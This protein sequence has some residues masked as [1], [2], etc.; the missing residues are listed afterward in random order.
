MKLIKI[1]FSLLSLLIGVVLC[2]PDVAARKLTVEQRLELLESELNANKSELQKTK[3]ELGRYKSKLANLQQTLTRDNHYNNSTNTV[4]DSSPIAENIK[5]ENGERSQST[6]NTRVNGTQQIAVIEHDGSNTNIESVSL[7][8]IS[9]FI[10]DDIGFSYQGYF[11]SGWGTSNQGS[12]KTY[13]AGSLGRFGNEMSGWF[14][15]TL[16]QRVYNQ[17][18]KTANAIVTYDG[19]VGEQYNDAWFGDSDNEN[20]MQF[21]DIYLTTRGFLPFAPDADFWVGKHKLPQYEIQML[22]WK[23]LTADVAAGVGIENWALG[24]GLLDASLS[25]DDVDV[26]SRDFSHT[27]QMNTNSVDLRYRNIPLWEN[28]TLSLMAKYS[29]PNKTDQ[30]EENEN[31]DSYFEMKDSWMLTSILHQNLER[32]AFNEFTLQVANNSFASSFSSF[33]DASNTM[34][35]GRYYYG[36]HTNGIAWRLISQGEMYLSDNIIVANALVYSHGEDIYSYESG[37]H[38][39]FDS[40]RTVI[41]P[42]WIWNTWN[43]TGVEL[44][45]FKQKN[46]T[47]QG[48]TLEESAYKTTLYHAFKVGNSIL[49]SRPEIRFYGTWINI[50]DNELSNFNFNDNSKDEFMAGVQAEV[51]W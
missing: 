32:D 50:L 27:T 7:K 41:R 2:P 49:G 18:G 28:G 16:N 48:I 29:S 26:Y 30:Q 12:P 24:P 11:R 19:N 38:S 10:K 36:D 39:D 33:S 44:G 40:V 51:W 17:D 45:W 37:A 21:S 14:D 3:N 42:A 43:Q 13:A 15:L 4:S 8:D 47:Q 5:N 22:D 9:K 31:N 46:K 1:K 23:T 25:R 34:A 35:H 6:R 20:I